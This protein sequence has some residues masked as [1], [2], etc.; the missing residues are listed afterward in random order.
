MATEHER[1]IREIMRKLDSQ[2]QTPHLRAAALTNPETTSNL[3]MAGIEWTLQHGAEGRQGG[4]KR[5]F[6]A[7][8]SLVMIKPG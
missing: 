6:V 7:A 8:G 2:T 5:T 4:G 3:F 1:L